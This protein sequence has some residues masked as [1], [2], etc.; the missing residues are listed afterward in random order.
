MGISFDLRKGCNVVKPPTIS[1]SSVQLARWFGNMQQQYPE[2]LGASVKVTNFGSHCAFGLRYADQEDTIR[3]ETLTAE[4]Q[5][6]L[7]SVTSVLLDREDAPFRTCTTVDF[8]HCVIPGLYEIRMQVEVYGYTKDELIPT[9]IHIVVHRQE[10][11]FCE[12]QHPV[13]NNT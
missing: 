7:N 13:E 5:K 11:P 2:I 4:L 8:G 10:I 12:W 9:K 6:I 1:H 3:E